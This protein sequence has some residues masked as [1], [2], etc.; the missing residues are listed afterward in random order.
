MSSNAGPVYCAAYG[1]NAAGGELYAVLSPDQLA[2]GQQRA[3]N[4]IAWSNLIADFDALAAM[5]QT[6]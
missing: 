4:G 2:R 3:P 6:T 5:C 1:V